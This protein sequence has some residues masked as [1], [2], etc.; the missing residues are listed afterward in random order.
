MRTIPPLRGP[1]FHA[2][3][4]R[5]PCQMIVLTSPP[6]QRDSLSDP[7]DPFLS[8]LFAPHDPSPPQL[9]LLCIISRAES[10]RPSPRRPLVRAPCWRAA[11]AERT[12]ELRS[13]RDDRP[14]RIC[15]SALVIHRPR[16]YSCIITVRMQEHGDEW[17]RL[18]DMPTCLNAQVFRP[19]CFIE[20]VYLDSMDPREPRYDRQD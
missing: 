2:M 8:F 4:P 15:Y 6:G 16:L 19:L 14:L 18:L 11:P 3:R 20:Q 12:A 13:T 7:G 1:Y 17:I 9:A 5:P 10:V